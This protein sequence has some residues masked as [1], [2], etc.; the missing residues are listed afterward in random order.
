MVGSGARKV[1]YS[2]LDYLVQSLDRRYQFYHFRIG[3]GLTQ[4][5]IFRLVLPGSATI[6]TGAIKAREM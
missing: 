5:Q 1:Q 4:A 2:W 3:L 6:G